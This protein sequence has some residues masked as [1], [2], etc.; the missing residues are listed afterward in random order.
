MAVTELETETKY[1]AG[2]EV[3]LPDLQQLPGVEATRVEQERLTAEYYDTADLRLLRAG[4]T[5]RR[6]TGGHDAGWHL[7][8]PAGPDSRREIRLPAGRPPGAARAG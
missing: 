8:L 7:K 3:T 5:L 4:I 6:R 2:T 1:E